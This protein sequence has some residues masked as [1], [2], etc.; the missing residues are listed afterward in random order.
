MQ[1]LTPIH[2]LTV[3]VSVAGL[4]ATVAALLTESITEFQGAALMM[5]FIAGS[6]FGLLQLMI[7]E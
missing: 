2:I 4:L 1:P 5:F 7:E 6:I 3:A